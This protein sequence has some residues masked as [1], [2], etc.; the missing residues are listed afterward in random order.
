[1]IFWGENRAVVIGTSKFEIGGA[2]DDVTASYSG[3]YYSYIFSRLHGS[4]EALKYGS[5]LDGL[6]DLTGGITESIQIKNDSTSCSRLTLN[7]TK[8]LM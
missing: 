2:H 5:L 4:Y 6:A 8:L 3:L 1:M 7:V